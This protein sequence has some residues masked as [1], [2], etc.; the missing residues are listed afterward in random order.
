MKIL[1]ED[2]FLVL[3]EKSPGCLSEDG[4]SPNSMP[5]LLREHYRGLGK[6]DYIASV[7]RLDK[8]VGGLMLYSRSP[9]ATGKLI[10]AVAEHQVAKEYLAVL[11][12]IPKEPEGV[13]RDLL[14]H[15]SSKNKT[16]VVKRERKGVREAELSYS[17]LE[18]VDALSLI[19]VRLHTGRTHQ[20]RAQFSSRGLPL[21]G[22]I[23]YG[24]KDPACDCALW[25]FHLAFSHPITGKKVDCSLMPP[26]EYPWNLFSL[27][28]GKS[29]L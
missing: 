29:P 21:L 15:D 18:T 28:S 7:H 11:K 10:A 17:L 20:I 8:I 4:P 1:Y 26:A 14:F 24:S 19:R 6:Q 9:K 13:L 27:T 23:R 12:G 3:A 2:P 25:S 16:F 22:D 5:A